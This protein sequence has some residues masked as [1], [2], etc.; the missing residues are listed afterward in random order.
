MNPVLDLSS[1]LTV[2]PA[3]Y[4]S[5]DFALQVRRRLRQRPFDCLAVALPPSLGPAVEAGVAALP[6]ISVAVQ[7]EVALDASYSYV[8]IDPCQA[9]IAAVREAVGPGTSSC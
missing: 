4:G 1:R 2:L 7:A 6:R 9:V 8:P 5:G 3:V